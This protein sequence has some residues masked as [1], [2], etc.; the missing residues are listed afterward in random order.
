[1][2]FMVQ[3]MI[4]QQSHSRCGMSHTYSIVYTEYDLPDP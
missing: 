1:M 4:L 2:H 3:Q